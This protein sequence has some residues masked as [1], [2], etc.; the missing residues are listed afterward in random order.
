[1]D[2]DGMTWVGHA[3]ALLEID[4]MRVLTDP[5]L[6][7][8]VGPLERTA[9]APSPEDSDEIDAVL[10]S[11]LHADHTDIPSLRRIG[12][13]TPVLAPKGAGAWLSRR[14]LE[15]VHE[16]APGETHR[17]GPLKVSATRA[18]HDG[19]RRPFGPSAEAV[20]Y[21]V[22]GSRS[23][24]YFAGDTDLFPD[25]AHLNGGIDLALLPV[26]GWGRTLGPGHLDPDRAATAAELIRPALAV[27][28][29]W[30]TFALP[31]GLSG[32]PDT[33]H[34]A[35]E[36]ARVA[37]DRAPDVGVRMLRPGERTAI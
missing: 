20:G 18:V 7:S 2:P 6:R 19:R 26:W 28:I 29:H 12:R 9:A 34:P 25:M 37:G 15:D 23:S 14:G 13:A 24:V 17:L 32:L 10:L 1:M 35:R 22:S 16:L 33:E 8:W 5:V 31:G 30:G 11:H 3:T 27:P 36:F 4:G 21:V